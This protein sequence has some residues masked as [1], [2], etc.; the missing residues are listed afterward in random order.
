MRDHC[1]FLIVMSKFFSTLSNKHARRVTPVFDPV[2]QMQ[3]SA[4]P[5]GGS[6]DDG[7][8]IERYKTA[9]RGK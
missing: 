6:G 5:L 4:E 3:L 2:D 7:Q 9:G 8:K 1:P